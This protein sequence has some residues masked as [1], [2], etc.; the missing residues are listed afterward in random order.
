MGPPKGWLSGSGDE[1]IQ[2]LPLL[3]AEQLAPS[4][5]VL[6]LYSPQLRSCGH[7]TLS[8]SERES[9]WL[10]DSKSDPC[11]KGLYD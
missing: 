4:D 8:V 6:W 7:G 10:S 9:C 2:P 1:L 3:L 11:S 5:V